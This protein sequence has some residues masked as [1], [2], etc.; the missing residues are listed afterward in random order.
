MFLVLF[1]LG[2]TVASS[3]IAISTAKA[4]APQRL[5]P[6]ITSVYVPPCSSPSCGGITTV[7]VDGANFTPSARIALV[8]GRTVY[9]E[10]YNA[11]YVGGDGSTEII[12]D[13]Y[14]LPGCKT[15]DLKLYFPYP[16]HRTV[17]KSKAVKTPC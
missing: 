10:P 3:N 14:N 1:L 4:V 2:L 6:A 5:R 9:Q 13:F 8:N 16:D 11:A 17:T 7:I 12:T 15:L